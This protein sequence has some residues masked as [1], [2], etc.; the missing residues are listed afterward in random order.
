MF[1]TWFE[2]LKA[3]FSEIW[4]LWTLCLVLNIIT[5]LFIFFKIH[6]GDKT[7]ALHYNVLIG[8]QWYGKGKNLYFLII[9][10]GNDS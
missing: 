7:L 5:F 6:P 1:N 9:S 8:V 3:Y 4:F 10:S 2:K